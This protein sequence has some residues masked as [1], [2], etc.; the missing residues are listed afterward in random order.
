ME[1]SCDGCPSSAATLRLAIEDA[2]HKVAP[3][4]ERVEAEGAVPDAPA[5]AP[6]LQLELAAPL[7]EAAA[8]PRRR[9]WAALDGLG[10]LADGTSLVRDVAGEAVLFLRLDGRPYAYRQP[11]PSCGVALG[12]G[13]LDGTRLTCAGCGRRYDARRAGRCLDAP[14]PNL[15]PLPLLSTGDGGLKVALGGGAG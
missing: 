5:A 15:E 11:C 13:E 2:I 4:I 9:A 1:G 8:A 12:D 3:E 10:D 14:G 7:P 6:L